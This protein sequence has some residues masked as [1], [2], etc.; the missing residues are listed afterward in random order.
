MSFNFNIFLYLGI[1]LISARLLGE[2]FEKLKL[3][4][5]LGELFAGFLFGGPIFLL[6]DLNEFNIGGDHPFSFIGE[7]GMKESIEPFAQ[8]GILLLLFIVGAEI[9][10]SEL[11]RSGKRNLLISLTDVTITYGLGFLFSYI[12]FSSTSNYHQIEGNA[13]IGVSAFFA[14]VF[15][16]TSIGTTVRTL[17]NIKR[18]N[19]KEGQTLL[20]LAVFDDFLGL[21]LL[22]II[23]GILFS[24]N[25]IFGLSPALSVIIQILFIGVLILAIL[26]ILPKILEFLE[27]RFNTFS[28]AST[29]YFSIG[30]VLAILL[31][32]AYFAE[33]LGVSAAIGA[34]LLGVGMQRNKYLM[35]DTLETFTKIGEGSFIP[36]FFFSVG[37]SFVLTQFNPIFIIIIPIIIV[38][39]MIGSFTGAMF[40]TNPLKDFIRIMKERFGETEEIVVEK[41]E[42]TEERKISRLWKLKKPDI[43]SSGRIATGMMPKGEITLV[44]SAVGLN[45]AIEF[46]A[47]NDSA[48]AF[49]NDL[50]SVVIILV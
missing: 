48:I 19:T 38:S 47:S 49:A 45:A 25:T 7:G 17:S 11:K 35:S 41:V 30:I 6:F 8:I 20:S 46:F 26:Y 2:L 50:Y 36:L 37:S 22:L 34:F 3:S 18:L 23:S 15:V 21:F 5:I 32:M 40:A 10:T 16:P 43:I 28:S 42:N 44:I 33:Y 24:G 14:L 27:S 12:L 31:I 1:A 13:I 29:S 9:K 39:K 4:S